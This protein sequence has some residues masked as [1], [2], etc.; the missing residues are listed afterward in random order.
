MMSRYLCAAVYL[1]P[2]V[3]LVTAMCHGVTRQREAKLRALFGV[4]RRTLERWRRWWQET[5]PQTRFWRGA[6]GRLCP[7]VER[8]TLPHSLLSRFRDRKK[9]TRVVRLLAFLGPLTT[10]RS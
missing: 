8:E 10:S 5:F 9:S 4:S 3:V 7:P 6:Q 1:A 2:V